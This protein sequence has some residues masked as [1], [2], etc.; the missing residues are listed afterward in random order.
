MKFE[1]L[2][3][4]SAPKPGVTKPAG[5]AQLQPKDEME[6][7]A[8]DVVELGHLSKDA[9]AFLEAEQ[10]IKHAGNATKLRDVAPLSTDTASKAKE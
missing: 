5:A 2:K 10:C 1:V 4:F 3:P 6:V 8:G 9:I 7:S